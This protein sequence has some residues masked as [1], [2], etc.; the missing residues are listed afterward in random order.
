MCR[1][2]AHVFAI[3]GDR[4]TSDLDTLP[5]Q[6][7]GYLFVCE[8]TGGILLLDHLFDHAFQDQQGSG[9]SSRTLH[10]FG[11]KVP[12][13]KNAL[14]RVRV[15]ARNSPADGR[16]MHPDFLGDLLYHHGPKLIDTLL[17][18]IDLAADDRL[19]DLQNRL[20]T[21]LDIFEQLNGGSVTVA[22][23]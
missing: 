20:F 15:F 16:W 21:L 19:A 10:G 9:R 18:E 14:R 4:T 17:Q 2:N 12:Q 6:T 13:L 5:L 23:V 3:F 1:R 7:L 22:H 8:R 11:E